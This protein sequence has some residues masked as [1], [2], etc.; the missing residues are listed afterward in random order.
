MFLQGPERP[1]LVFTTLFFDV[2]EVGGHPHHRPSKHLVL[3]ASVGFWNTSFSMHG[4]SV[5]F[6]AVHPS[7]TSSKWLSAAPSLSP[8]PRPPP[9][10]PH[11]AE[12]PR[13][14]PK[15]RGS[16][17]QRQCLFY[18]SFSSFL[19]NREDSRCPPALQRHEV[20]SG[21]NVTGER[22]GVGG[23]PSSPSC[24]ARPCQVRPASS[25]P[26]KASLLVSRTQDPSLCA[27][28]SCF[29]SVQCLS[30]VRLF[31]TPWTV[32]YQ[33]PP[34]MEFSRQEYWSGVHCL[35]QDPALLYRYLLNAYYV[36]ARRLPRGSIHLSLLLLLPC[37]H[38]A[39]LC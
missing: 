19:V 25:R 22:G 20:R 7:T 17:P 15:G 38:T 2:R 34:S 26:S 3:A 5:T 8:T 14:A 23:R 31:A 13:G 9:P 10:T 29:S 33:A 11:P 35:L 37:W 39:L 30:R 24:S 1:E 36:L 6:K 18:Q 16:G 4:D 28:V 12:H 32:A 27:C 21:V